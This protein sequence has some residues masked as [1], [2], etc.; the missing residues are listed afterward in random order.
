MPSYPL[1]ALTFCFVFLPLVLPENTL[2]GKLAIHLFVAKEGL[3]RAACCRLGA[4]TYVS[5]LF[6]DQS[7]I[8]SCYLFFISFGV[9]II[10]ISLI[11]I[12]F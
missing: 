8:K 9:K 12:D 1:V 4:F 6:L 2:F 11:F 10:S 7:Q 5:L 3:L